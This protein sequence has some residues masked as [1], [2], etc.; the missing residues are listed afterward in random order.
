[1]KESRDNE[2]KNNEG[3][4]AE[5]MRI[6]TSFTFIFLDREGACVWARVCVCACACAQTHVV[7]MY[8]PVRGYFHIVSVMVYFV[9]DFFLLNDI[10]GLWLYIFRAFL[11]S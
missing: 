4:S 3:Q 2:K 1:M 5:G 6:T 9:L 7:S 11:S 8:I 10:K